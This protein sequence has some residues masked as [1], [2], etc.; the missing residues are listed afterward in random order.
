MKK[1]TKIIVSAVC[2]FLVLCAAAANIVWYKLAGYSCGRDVALGDFL[3]A[4]DVRIIGHRGMAARAP[5]NTL[6]SFRLSCEKGCYGSE[7][8]V[9][10]TSDGEFVIMHDDNVDRL[11]DGKG[12][13]EDKTY[14]E[15]RA[16]KFV[17]GN[18]RRQY[19]RSEIYA[20]TLDEYLDVLSEYGVVP[21]I[22]LKKF[23]V[24]LL[25]EFV[26]ILGDHGVR[27]KAAVISFSYEYLAELNSI[28]PDITLYYLTGAVSEDKIQKCVDLG[29]GI[30]F[31]G[32]KKEND[33]FIAEC[34]ANNVPVAVWTIDSRAR[35]RALY[36]LGV[37]VFTSNC[38]HP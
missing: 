15:M 2:A 23:D 21:V 8:D 13:I 27:N 33:G 35:F 31:D 25:P 17:H 9:H 22:E 38:I 14:E 32:N 20:P 36:G 28:A 12:N 19:D 10:T 34:L 4:D 29:C 1:K 24:S 6:P 26:K 37:R 16:L 7:C 30:D 18:R 3:A 5:E 11:T